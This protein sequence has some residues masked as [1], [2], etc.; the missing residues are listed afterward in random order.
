MVVA[1]KRS[2]KEFTG[3][4]EDHRNNYVDLNILHENKVREN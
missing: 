4:K 1:R 3:K 2:D